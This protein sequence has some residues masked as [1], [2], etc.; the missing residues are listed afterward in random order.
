MWG[1]CSKDPLLGIVWIV[2]GSYVTG[3]SQYW[4]VEPADLAHVKL[5]QYVPLAVT[6][7]SLAMPSLSAE[8]TLNFYCRHDTYCREGNNSCFTEK[9]RQHS[10]PW[11]GTSQLM[12]WACL[13]PG[14]II[15]SQCGPTHTGILAYGQCSSHNRCCVCFFLPMPKHIQG[16]GCVDRSQCVRQY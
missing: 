3:H 15:P 7:T 2:C 1:G 9:R 13:S 4:V 6:H 16:A 8:P 12:A 14:S 11:Y 10:G 5:P